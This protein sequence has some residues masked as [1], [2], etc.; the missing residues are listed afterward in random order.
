MQLE[1]LKQAVMDSRDGITISE[2]HGAENP[3]I[4]VNP[5]F[6]RMTGYPFEE[7]TRID[8]RYLQRDDHD[9]PGLVVLR[10]AI[11]QGQHCLVTLRNYRRDGSMFWNELSLSPIFDR[12]GLVSHF[13][14]IQKDITARV[15]LEEHL[16]GANQSLEQN[17][18]DL[19]KLAT[20]DG[21][22][23]IYNRRYFDAQL[24]IL[25][26]IGRRDRSSLSLIFVDVD[27]FKAYNDHFGHPAGDAALQSVA[28]SL[29]TSFTR[30]SD[31]VARYGGEEFVVLS[32]AMTM[33][34]TARFARALCERV[35]SLHVPH[36]KPEG[37][38]LMIS[39]GFAVQTC[40]DTEGPA[41]LV[42]AADKALYIAK[43]RG[44]DQS[45]GGMHVS[46]R[47]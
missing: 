10:E 44:R 34:N 43:Q 18:R 37:G 23:G 24:D 30:V 6:E 9:Q 8:C 7:S 29:N 5:A 38:F 2:Y 22:T 40:S 35:R 11:A 12:S 13:I 42:D 32:A 31:F 25:W 36:V 3:L 47:A 1:L 19:E 39:A 16:V 33:E 28:H 20:M 14:G 15:I 17:K 41:A 46:P 21:L 4:F 26:R 45:Y 27:H